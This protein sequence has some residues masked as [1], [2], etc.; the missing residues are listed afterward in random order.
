MKWKLPTI[1]N[2]LSKK[3]PNENIELIIYNIINMQRTKLQPIHPGEI[4]SEEFIKLLNI[5]QYKLAKDINVPAMRISEIIR[6][7]RSI[8]A[9]TAL[10]LGKYFG[11]SPRFWL[12]LQMRYDLERQ[13]DIL[14]N[15][16][17]KEVKTLAVA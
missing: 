6:G 12:N 8:T 9:D 16:L 5:S 3:F 17:D 2:K 11:N 14:A 15:K 1:I 13:E 4:L 7:N 10:R